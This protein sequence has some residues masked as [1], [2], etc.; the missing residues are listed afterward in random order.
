MNPL[1][2]FTVGHF[3]KLYPVESSFITKVLLGRSDLKN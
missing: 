2:S 1:K 3:L